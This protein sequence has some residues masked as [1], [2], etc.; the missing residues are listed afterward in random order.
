MT[1]P[2]VKSRCLPAYMVIDTSYSMK[3][4]E[5]LLND[6]VDHVFEQLSSRPMVSEFAH[7]SIIT[8]NSDAHV[9]LEMTDIDQVQHLP[10]ISCQ[11]G[12]SYGKAFQLVR[13]RIDVDVTQLHAAGRAV[14]RPA[15][16]ILTDGAPTDSN[17]AADFATLT[18][19]GFRRRPHIIAYG[20]G[21]ANP[22]VLG[23]IATKAAFVAKDTENEKEAIVSMLTSLLNTLV[24]S[25]SAQE[26]R[27][28]EQ[29]DGYERVPIEFVD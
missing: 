16:F 23:K 27:I 13:Q 18:D 4:Q 19:Q 12:T 22:A 26:F 17:W 11:G 6:T 9:V 1:E 15:V 8:F 2:V 20:F 24:T 29:A 3:S 5:Q 28:P 7:I 21:A 10:T 25:A 14:L